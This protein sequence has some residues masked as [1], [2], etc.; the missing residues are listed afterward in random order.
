M[1]AHSFLS[2]LSY[3]YFFFQLV[4]KIHATETQPYQLY[5]IFPKKTPAKSKFDFL[6]KVGVDNIGKICRDTG[7]TDRRE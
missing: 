7:D 6:D 5:K 4:I 3:A 1:I 2:R